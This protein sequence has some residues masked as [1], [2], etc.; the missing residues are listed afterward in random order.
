LGQAATTLAAGS[1][2]SI[3]TRAAE[4]EASTMQENNSQPIPKKPL[5]KTGLEVS[6]MGMGGYSLADAPTLDEAKQMVREA[7]DAGLNFFDNAW[8][9]H[10]GRSEQWLG[11][12]LVGLRDK[13]VLMTKVCTHGRDKKVAMQQLE[14]SLR[15]LK[16][17][18]LDLWQIHECVY[19]NDPD[20]HFAKGGVVEALDEAK[21]AGKVR[22]V[23]FTG[24]KDP[25]IHLKMLSHNYPFD[26]VQ[27]PLNP[28]D[29][30]YRSF[31]KLVL[32]E[33]NTRGMAAL[34]MKSL[35]G[36][37]QA[38]INMPI[39]PQEALR[40]AMSLPVATTISGMDSLEVLHQNLAVARGFKP[41][42]PEEMRELE[43]RCAADAG[44]GHLEMY[45]STKKFD[46]AVGRKMHSFPP[47][48]ELPL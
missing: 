4:S 24:H 46:A 13:V 34:G 21:K 33:V 42:S 25:R 6:A 18:H 12:C 36:G 29:A 41:Y 48:E 20:W 31:Q 8:E 10:D 43:Q 27:M 40:Y 19:F 16:T 17:D 30:S 35:C 26:S 45:K 38:V 32:P 7:V 22:F 14:D 11:E 47:A 9:Y 44:D 39:T 37:G 3:A 28:F 5:G 23:G 15:R 1:L 2:L